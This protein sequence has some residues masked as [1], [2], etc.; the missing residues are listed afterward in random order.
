MNNAAQVQDQATVDY[1]TFIKQAFIDPIRTVSIVD[2]EYPTLDQLLATEQTLRSRGWVKDHLKPADALSNVTNLLELIR[3]F[4]SDQNNWMIDVYDGQPIE[5]S[6]DAAR[7]SKHLHHSDLLVLDY[8]LDG[9]QDGKSE[10]ALGILRQLSQIEHYNLVVVH[11][12]GYQSSPGSVDPIV[13]DIVLSLSR[14]PDF[15]EIT[16]VLEDSVNEKIDEWSDFDGFGDIRSLLLESISALDFMSMVRD[17]GKAKHCNTCLESDYAREFRALS[18]RMPDDVK[19]T[20]NILF[21][22]V[23]TFRYREL[24]GLFDE[25]GAEQVDWEIDGGLNWIRTD[26]VFITVVSKGED[27][28]TIPERLLQALTH[29][30]PHPHNLLLA[31]LRH[32]LDDR[33]V[34]ITDGIL[35][36]SYIQ[37]YW[38]D[39]LLK[40]DDISL[41]SK[42]WYVLEKHW[43]ELALSTKDSLSTFTEEIISCLKSN[44]SFED[45]RKDY[46]GE[47]TL[48]NHNQ[49]LAHANCF[50]CS[51]G[52]VGHH[53]TT[54]HVLKIEIG[55]EAQYWLCLSPAC[56][57]EPGQK[58]SKQFGEYLPVKFVQLFKAKVACAEDKQ[59]LSDDEALAAALKVSQR[60]E[61]LFLNIDEKVQPFCFSVRQG[62]ANP[63]WHQFYAG[64]NGVF[65]DGGNVTLSRAKANG[66]GALEFEILEGEVV[67]QLRY[68]YALNLLQKLGTVLS[69]IGLDFATIEETEKEE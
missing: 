33:G 41:P 51:T 52:V 24:V 3:V 55:N 29:W 56:D 27:P 39:E 12:K 68:E 5:G 34:S 6:T 21:W 20:I 23:L 67:A 50:S 18:E 46:G 25:A 40:A 42:A 35:G 9:E 2:D 16:Q 28:S 49:M 48:A 1:S 7:F 64:K 14:A 58:L 22:Y 53:L 10:Y 45:I 66:D 38:L 4:R 60:N 11:T 15:Q 54:G 36:K 65:R 44:A 43:S 31:K 63:K 26:R 13:Q 69:R 32:E 61:M 57:I 47:S 19:L 17:F 37:A 30:N 59:S 8:H 62:K